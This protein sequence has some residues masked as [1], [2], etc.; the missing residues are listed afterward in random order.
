MIKVVVI[1]KVQNSKDIISSYIQNMDDVEYKAGFNSFDEIN[2]NFSNIDL[3]IFDVDFE[4]FDKV[5]KNVKDIKEKYPNLNF[6]AISY[7]INP[8][9]ILK[10]KEQ[11]IAQILLKPIISNILEASI[12]KIKNIKQDNRNYTISVF[13]NKGACGKTSLATNL[14]YEISKLTNEKTAIVDLSFNFDDVSTALDIEAK[15]DF[16]HALIEIERADEKTILNI[17]NRY[18]NSNLYIFS[19]KDNLAINKKISPS[20]IRKIIRSI[21]NIFKYT[22]ID[23]PSTIDETTVSI[24]D[25]STLILLLAM[26]NMSSI[27][28]IQKCLE[29]FRHIGFSKLKTKLIINRFI[30]NSEITIEDFEHTVNYEIFQ[31]IPNNYLTLIDAINTGCLV[32]ELNPN[33]NIAKSYISIASSVVNSDIMNIADTISNDTRSHGIFDLIKKIGE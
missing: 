32:S 15:Y 23:T 30:E 11:G 20:D 3:I 22:I 18:K 6:I 1:D 19:F 16:E 9:F 26:L 5:F 2:I 24:L 33:S 31:K 12:N 25:N 21:K 17:A 10:V 8:Q 27:R 28:N 13:S 7:E 14:A 29:L 4:T